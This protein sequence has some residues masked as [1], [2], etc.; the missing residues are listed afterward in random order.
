MDDQL[1]GRRRAKRIANAGYSTT[2]SQLSIGLS[3]SVTPLGAA[4]ISAFPEPDEAVTRLPPEKRAPAR[5]RLF[6]FSSNT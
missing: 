6:R 4:L 1:L 2:M 3:S 5:P